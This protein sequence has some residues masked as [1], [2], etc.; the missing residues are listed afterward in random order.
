MSRN[1]LPKKTDVAWRLKQRL[2]RR[3]LSESLRSTTRQQ[4]NVKNFAYLISKNNSFIRLSRS[5]S[6]FVHF[7]P[8]LGKFATQNDQIW[9][10]SEHVSKQRR[11]LIFFPSVPITSK[12]QYP[13]TT[14]KPGVRA[15]CPRELGLSL[16]ESLL[17]GFCKPRVFDYFL[18]P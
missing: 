11:I 1:A 4:S 13:P 6:I 15:V 17:A 18:W 7:F 8:V 10:F 14:C 16:S 5:V 9:S 12:L 2:R 3:R